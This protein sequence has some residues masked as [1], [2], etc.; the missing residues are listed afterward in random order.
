MFYPE[1]I[2]SIGLRSE[3]VLFDHISEVYSR[4][5]YLVV[6][7]P[8]NPKYISANFV[9]FKHAPD[10]GALDRWPS[11]FAKEF[12]NDV[13]IKHVK[14][15]WDGITDQTNSIRPFLDSGFE[16][17]HYRALV[18]NGFLIEPNIHQEI[19]I[20]VISTNEEWE[21]ILGDQMLLKP[22]G[23]SD[24]YYKEFSSQ[25]IEDHISIVGLGKAIWFGAFIGST[26]VGS[27]GLLWSDELAVFHRVI[28]KE[29][30]Q[31]QGICKTLLYYI[32]QWISKELS[33]RTLVILAEK[34][35]LAEYIYQSLGF[36]VK[37][38][39]MAVYRNP[40]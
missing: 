13:N 35:S 4:E 20:R 11:L 31:K 14:L 23:L 29:K 21:S 18:S 28:V 33:N 37:E 10:V 30:F 36:K 25:L 26:M 9:L 34:G 1:D 16:L 24:D 40:E 3:F 7:T 6:K 19:E 22:K 8:R 27:A 2:S 12:E 39:L 5:D 15:I 38:E 32:S 17:G